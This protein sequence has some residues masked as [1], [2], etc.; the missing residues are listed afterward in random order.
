V[1]A[2]SLLALRAKQM[3]AASGYGPEYYDSVLVM[4]KRQKAESLNQSIAARK[5]ATAVSNE[6]A[7]RKVA[8]VAAAT[9][10]AGR[11]GG[12]G[13]STIANV[14][15]VGPYTASL[16]GPQLKGR[17]NQAYGL[18]DAVAGESGIQGLASKSVASADTYR[19]AAGELAPRSLHVMV[20]HLIQGANWRGR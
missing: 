15:S 6:V 13:A 10:G 8:T 7:A 20:V 17:S 2:D 12:R 3:A 1:N 11:R 16:S 18:Q 14:D 19:F 5:Q 9:A 4:L